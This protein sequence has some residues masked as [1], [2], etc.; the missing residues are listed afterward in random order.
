MTKSST[1]TR[2][3][4]IGGGSGFWGDSSEGF[5]QMVEKGD[6]QYLILDYLAEIT[7]SI[8]ARMRQKNEAMGYVPEFV[9]LVG[10][11][12]EKLANKKI[13]VIA[14]AGGI[15]PEA[16]AAALRVVLKEKGIGMKVAAVLGDDVSP[17]L[18]DLR[19][20]GTTEMSSG[21]ELPKKVLSANAYIG[22]FPI[23]AALAEN[24]DIVVV[25]RCADSALVLGPLIHEFG[26]KPDDYDLLASGSLA[27]HVI[28]CGPQATGGIFT[29]WELVADGWADI[30]YP[31][32]ICYPDGTFDVTKPP[33][34]GGLVSW[35]TVAEQITY[36]TGDPRAY[37]LPDVICDLTQVNVEE[38][39]KDRVRV[40]GVRGTGSPASYKVSATFQDGYRCIA[41][42]LLRGADASPKGR[43]VANSVL[44]R[45]RSIFLRRNLGDFA[46]T[47]IEI[48]GAED[49]FGA[50]SASAAV[51]EVVIK[52]A[53]RHA[54]R[55][56]AEIFSRE[57]A[58]ATVG[59]AQGLA[60]IMGGR[61][62]V[63]P[64]VRLFSF[65]VDKS[66]VPLSVA[67]PDRTVDVPT[68]RGAQKSP[69]EL[70]GRDIVEPI[71]L[72]AAA[73]PQKTV[74]VPL[75]K[76][77]YGRSGDKGNA[78][79]VAVLARKKEFLPLIA[80]QVTDKAVAGYMAH[81]V[82]GGVTRFDWPGLR[83][84]NFLMEKALGGGGVASLRYDPQGKAHGQIL[85]EMPV[86]VPV[87]LIERSGV[88]QRT[89]A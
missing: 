5:V 11:H 61:P 64:V 76:I 77:A 17:L 89:G 34:T 67:F 16:C 35:A 3:V 62:K 75:R 49:G 57:I 23:A 58:P 26:W 48:L 78:S 50:N 1:G 47:S 36:E 51:R 40:S 37:F 24:A 18:D 71:R 13:K 79:N 54:E 21:E 30:G 9:T 84:F 28:E 69:D 29:D 73:A 86:E 6:V 22:A 65:L 82:E 45:C 87:D 56:G 2:S 12:A 42:L 32:A 66:R 53:V 33:E 39:A 63:Q 44:N 85:L 74:T 14:N 19:R 68:A 81:L 25:G 43:A 46:E 41:T 70:S 8:L 88:D 80:A 72:T 38:T 59:M 31:I 4:R 27:G 60:G 83:G 10:E 20:E 7:M 15:N 55:E 52:I